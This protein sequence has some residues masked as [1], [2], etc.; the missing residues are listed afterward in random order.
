[1]TPL[2][3]ILTTVGTDGDV[4]PYVALGA[5]L[6]CRGN[7]ATLVA[8]EDYRGLAQANGLGFRALVSREQNDVCFGNPDF[9]HV[10]KGP[11]I[12]ARWG[13]EFLP[14]QFEL[15]AELA[16]DG[17]TVLVSSPGV[18]AARLVQEKLGRP[19]ASVILQPWM[20]RS[21]TAPPV[22]P[23]GL[24]LPRWAPRP[25]GALYWRGIDA[26]GAVLFGR[27]LRALRDRLGLGPTGPVF[28]WWLSPQRVIGM[29]P[30]WYGPPQ[31]DWAENIRLTGFPMYDG[32]PAADARAR[33]P[34]SS[35]LPADVSAFLESGGPP[36]AFTFGT[37]MRHAGAV[38]RAAAEACRLLGKRGL[39]LTKYADQ[40]PPDLPPA[41]RHVPYAP[42]Q[43]LFPRCAAVVHHGGIGTVAK[44]L[45]AGIPQVV[46]PVAYDQTDN[47]TRVKRLGV[48][49]WLMA[50][51][52]TAV[53]L[54]ALIA[55]VTAP[56]VRDGSA[57]LKLRFK[58]GDDALTTAS[59]YVEDLGEL[60][61]EPTAE[62]T[63]AQADRL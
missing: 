3:V 28:R 54:G 46:L 37:G 19:M 17:R 21:S 45:A 14:R 23:A 16:R 60:G 10:L 49:E 36:V 43:R 12:G 42:F 7:R 33:D 27:P 55:N 29:F 48:G 56:A 18:L 63:S 40:L 59:R 24:T 62:L 38:F 15:L 53:R 32:A 35:G 41:V 5:A 13:V 20:I 57:K 47:A 11:F 31:A 4:F 22:M 58:A 52:L 1:M 9:W 50:R 39:L 61:T 44:A 26:T 25:L 30:D 6:V 51:K 2:H 34:D 8:S